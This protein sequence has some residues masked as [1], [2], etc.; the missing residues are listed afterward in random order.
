MPIKNTITKVKNYVVARKQPIFNTLILFGISATS[1]AVVYLLRASE[2]S[3]DRDDY[4]RERIYKIERNAGMPIH[5][6]DAMYHEYLS[7]EAEVVK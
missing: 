3:L 5:E 4:L 2:V 1:A 7:K 6:Q